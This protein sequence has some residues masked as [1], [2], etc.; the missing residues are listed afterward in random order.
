MGQG[1][2]VTIRLLTRTEIRHLARELDVR[3]RK[4]LHQH[5]VHDANTV[6]RIVSASAVTKHDHILEVGAG[7]GSLTLGLLDRGSTITAVEIDPVLAQRLPTTIAEHCHSEIHRLTVLTR[8]IS[9]VTASELAT[10]PTAV[11][12]NLPHTIIEPVLFYLM[13]EFPSIRTIMIMV[14]IDTAHQLSAEP[15][16]KAYTALSAKIRFFG[17]IRHYG[18][19]SPTVFWPIPRVHYGLVRLD[20]Y[21]TP[22][23]PTTNE[24]QDNINGLI[25][26][27]FTQ[28]RK[29]VRNAFLDWAGSGNHSAERLLAASIDPAR[30]GNTLTIEEFVRLYQRSG[31]T[32]ITTP[33]TAPSA[34]TATTTQQPHNAPP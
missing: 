28:R 30:H 3:P 8:N 23:W 5:F 32:P 19:V 7:F 6:R 18:T 27:A 24:F 15:G 17:T 10:P 12:I 2:S 21:R 14:H 20:R 22:P 13:N 29:T 9:D 34:G 26:I 25:D 33:T 1:C 16:M 4:A 31:D 11:L